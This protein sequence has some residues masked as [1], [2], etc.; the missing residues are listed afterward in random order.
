M[1]LIFIG[2]IQVSLEILKTIRKLDKDILVGII[3]NRNKKPDSAR[4]DL[5]SK[6]FGIP[7]ILTRNVN[8]IKSEKWIKSKRP[9]LILCV[10]WSQILKKNILSIPNK[11]CIGF[12]PTKL[13]HNKGK[14][15]L[16]W[17]IINDLK[18]SSTSFFIMNNKIDDGDLI[19]Q[20]KFILGRDEYV[21]SIY[22]KLIKNSKSQIKDLI[23]KIKSNN[24]VIKK[25][26]KNNKTYNYWRKRKY[27]DGK[28]DFRMNSRSIF[29]LVRA[30]LPIPR[31]TF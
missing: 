15:P 17:S 26:N 14:H 9:D 13:P 20:K 18:V 30:L 19:S 1:R 2:N 11:Y 3:T 23:K 7:Y 27:S 5:F 29:N 22:K 8:N 12:H 6:K 24:L 10:G 21:K 25:I 16:I 31:S 4:V 28:I